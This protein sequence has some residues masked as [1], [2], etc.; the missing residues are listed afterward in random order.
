MTILTALPQHQHQVN[1]DLRRLSPSVLT[2]AEVLAR[3]GY[4]TAAFVSG[5]YLRAEYGFYQ[6]FDHY[7]DYSALTLL[8]DAAGAVTSPT[9]WGLVRSWLGDWDRSGRR[10]PFFVFLHM[11]DVHYDY[12]PPEP[13]R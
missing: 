6:G 2:L 8:D 13:L 10:K 12:I 3:S 7:D 9:L 1:V 5:P 4:S 11:W